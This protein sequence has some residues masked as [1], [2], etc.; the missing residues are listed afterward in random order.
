MMDPMNYGISDEALLDFDQEIVTDAIDDAVRSIQA[1]IEKE[2]RGAYRADYDYCYIGRPRY[3]SDRDEPL[4]M[5]YAVLPTNRVVE[6]LSDD[7]EYIWTEYTLDADPD[8][9]RELVHS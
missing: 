4:H 5:D 8:E 3:I 7:P 6:E 9:F 1:Q 2:L